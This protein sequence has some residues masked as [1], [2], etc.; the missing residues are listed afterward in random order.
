M[1]PISQKSL[2]I[3][4]MLEQYHNSVKEKDIPYHEWIRF[5]DHFPLDENKPILLYDKSKKAFY[6]GFSFVALQ[7]TLHSKFMN[8][9]NVP[10]H[11]MRIKT[12]E[13]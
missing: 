9:D 6:D 3:D 4:H 13:V 7:H 5:E 11:W 10:S 1:E 8:Y 12:P 2:D